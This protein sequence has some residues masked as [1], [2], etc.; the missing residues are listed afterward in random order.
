MELLTADQ[1]AAL[2]TRCQRS[3]WHLEMRDSYAVAEEA[4]DVAAWRA[5]E[6]TRERDAA[7]RG[8]WLDLMRATA[9]RGVDLRRARIVSEPVSEYIR[10]E[11]SGTPLTIEAGEQV[12]WLNR[13]RAGR[14]LVP[15]ADFW[16][17][18]RETLVLNHF[19]GDGSWAANEMITDRA[20]TGPLATS[21]LAIWEAGIPH[22]GY[23]LT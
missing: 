11:H 8:D 21:F 3:A 20:V 12:R 5:G 13:V 9:A 10:F 6:W 23:V 1:W 17:F 22:D 18:D 19:D 7:K 14:M 16:L 2:F 15:G 4:E